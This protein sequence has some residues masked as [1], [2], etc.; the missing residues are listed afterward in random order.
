MF[1]PFIGCAGWNSKLL[2]IVTAVHAPQVRDMFAQ[3]TCDA[4]AISGSSSVGT[5]RPLTG[6][7][8][9]LISALALDTRVLRVEST[10]MGRAAVMRYELYSS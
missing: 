8:G 6:A 5:I 4:R 10:A 7:S 3:R 1:G 9:G 2:H